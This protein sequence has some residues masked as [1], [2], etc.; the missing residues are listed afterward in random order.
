M[1]F[2]IFPMVQISR[3]NNFIKYVLHTSQTLFLRIL[4]TD[5]QAGISVPRDFSCLLEIWKY[6]G[7]CVMPETQFRTWLFLFC[8]FRGL[9]SSMD[10]L[11]VLGI[12]WL[13]Q[14]G[15]REQACNS[16]VCF[17]PTA[18]RFCW[19]WYP[20]PR[21]ELPW[22]KVSPFCLLAFLYMHF[23]PNNRH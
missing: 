14:T 22:G 5:F 6:R 18:S 15:L 21:Y 16:S 11:S 20:Q 8:S 3:V 9:T 13:M 10:W 23:L 4:I 12:M 17:Q 2:K 7:S 1:T 19:W